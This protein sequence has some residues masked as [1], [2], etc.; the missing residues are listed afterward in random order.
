MSE[1]AIDANAVTSHEQDG[2]VLSGVGVTADRL[3]ETME[4]HAPSESDSG[5]TAAAGQ[6][7]ETGS[8]A[9]TAQDAKPTRGQQRFSELAKA[10]DTEKARADAAE[11]RAKE[12]E[13]R[14]AA[15]PP[16]AAVPPVE[17][18][19]EPAK[20]AAKPDKFD[21]PDYEEFLT[22]NSNA[23]YK[24]FELERFQ[25]FD[26]WKDARASASIDER[27][28]AR[29]A[30][31]RASR[32]LDETVERTRVKGREAYADFDAVL[33]S[34]PGAAVNMH[35][36][37]AVASRRIAMIFH[38]PQ[39]E[40]LQYA[41]M[42]DGAL[43]AKL[44]GMDDLA[45]GMEIARLVPTASPSRREHVPPPAPFTPVNGNSATTQTASSE[46]ASKG[47][48]FDRSGYREKRAAERKRAAGR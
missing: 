16:T 12:L 43:A 44:A 19:T 17:A 27:I 32:T 36:D 3:A 37:D 25:A 34:G 6:A 24:D 21:F 39:S 22:T 14:V 9:P 48:D 42:K 47:F 1:T 29:L 4:R 7:A 30:S 38:H 35:A 2:R 31:E 13:A 23:S 5:G 20:P 46:L 10:R 28:V 45:F 15:Q 11:A 33:K 26:A 8:P 40:H 41:I 18:K